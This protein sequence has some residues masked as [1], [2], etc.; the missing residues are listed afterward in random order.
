MLQSPRAVWLMIIFS[1]TV[2]L[3]ETEACFSA[4]GYSR[5]STVCMSLARVLQVMRRSMSKQTN[6]QTGR[7]RGPGSVSTPETRIYISNTS[8]YFK[9]FLEMSSD[10]SCKV[11]N[12]G[13]LGPARVFTRPWQQQSNTTKSAP[14]ETRTHPQ[15]SRLYNT[16]RKC[17]AFD[18]TNRHGAKVVVSDCLLL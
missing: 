15:L 9:R 3:L 4:S 18:G 6:R 8:I 14:S 12:K 5:Q 11:N 10:W 17:A 16:N 1:T 7:C 2:E 13:K